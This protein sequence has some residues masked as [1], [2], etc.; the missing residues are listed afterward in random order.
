MA[1]RLA[2]AP[3]EISFVARGA[4]MLD[5]VFYVDEDGDGL[6]EEIFGEPVAQVDLRLAKRFTRHLELFVGVDNL[7]D[8]GDTFTALRPFTVYGGARGRY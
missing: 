5:R 4:L 2:Y 8:A 1:A 7:L 6:E 3:W